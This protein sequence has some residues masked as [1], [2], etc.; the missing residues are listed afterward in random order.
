MIAPVS[1]KLLSLSVIAARMTADLPFERNRKIAQP[2]EPVI[3][4]AIE[5]F[6]RLVASMALRNGS[7]WPKSG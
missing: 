5:E 2:V 3:A 7:S 1:S 4:R 6:P